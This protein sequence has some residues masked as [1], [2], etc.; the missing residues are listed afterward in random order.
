MSNT[1][2]IRITEG[3]G[4]DDEAAKVLKEI[5]GKSFT[6]LAKDINLQNQEAE[7]IPKKVNSE[8]STPS[9]IIVKLLNTKDKK[10]EIRKVALKHTISREL[11]ERQ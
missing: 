4:T 9:H 5:V 6:N 1:H 8:K 2:V 10:K 7:R 3:E 11:T